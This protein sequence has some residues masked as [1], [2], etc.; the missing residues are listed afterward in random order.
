LQKWELPREMGT[1]TSSL[2]PRWAILGKER[3]QGI[4]RTKIPGPRR[5]NAVKNAA[6]QSMAVILLGRPPPTQLFERDSFPVQGRK[7]EN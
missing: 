3:P 4:K 1:K 2:I 5:T 6:R 7:E